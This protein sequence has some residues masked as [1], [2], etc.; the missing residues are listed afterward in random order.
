MAGQGYDDA[1]EQAPLYLRTT[2][3]MLKE[4]EYLGED[5]GFF[6]H[7]QFLHLLHAQFVYLFVNLSVSY[8]LNI[9]FGNGA[10]PPLCRKNLLES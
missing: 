10:F 3:E 5:K 2:E 6:E 9:L 1:D 4:F 8:F 7:V